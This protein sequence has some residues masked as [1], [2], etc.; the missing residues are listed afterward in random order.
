[1]FAERVRQCMK[2]QLGDL[3]VRINHGKS[4]L[5]AEANRVGP[6]VVTADESVPQSFGVK[7]Q[8]CRRTGCRRIGFISSG[9]IL[10]GLSSGF[11]S[12]GFGSQSL[13]SV[14]TRRG[15]FLS[16]VGFS[17]ISA[18]WLCD[19]TLREILIP[20]GLVVRQSSDQP[21]LDTDVPR[22][23]LSPRPLREDLSSARYPACGYL[24]DAINPSQSRV[25]CFE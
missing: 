12:S 4:T 15:L 20:S 7:S 22:R 14:P 24:R 25:K 6:S 18:A 19:P 5:F 9:F 11:I 16:V 23:P 17:D 13:E 21:Q 8:R 3:V 10:S 2:L 1:M